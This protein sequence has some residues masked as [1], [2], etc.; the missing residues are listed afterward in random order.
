MRR[1]PFDIGLAHELDDDAVRILQAQHRF[2]ELLHGTSHRHIVAK[3]ARQP[4]ADR[5]R[6]YRKRDLRGL[7]EPDPS[8]RT[9]LPRQERDQRAGAGCRV[10]V[11]EM[12]LVGVLVA[13][14]PL[15][16]PQAEKA[17]IEIDVLLNFP[18][19]RRDVMDATGHGAPPFT[20]RKSGFAGP[21]QPNDSEWIVHK[22]RP[23]SR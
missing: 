6:L 23:A 9:I 2:A 10:A 22:K 21:R 7:T 4:E 20:L 5:L 11:E 17:C 1:R 3:R 8:G 13:G 18:G 15:D 14:R 16:E 19:D 12:K